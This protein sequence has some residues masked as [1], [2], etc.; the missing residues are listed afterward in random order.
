MPSPQSGMQVFETSLVLRHVSPKAS[1]S[2]FC[3]ATNKFGTA[4]SNVLNMDVLC[5]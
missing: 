3:K 4:T 5:K 1:G 2:Y